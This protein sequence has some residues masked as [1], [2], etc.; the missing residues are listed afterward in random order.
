MAFSSLKLSGHSRRG[1]A[2]IIV[3]AF[4]V[5]LTG[6]LVAFFSL[7]MS[8]RQVSNSS[9]NGGKTDLFARG[10]IDSVVGDFK[11]EIVAGSAVP[12]PLSADTQIAINSSSNCYL[13]VTGTTSTFNPAA[14]PYV[15]GSTTSTSTGIT[16]LAAN[17]VKISAYNQPFYPKGTFYSSAGPSRAADVSTSGTT[18]DG[19]YMTPARWNAALLLP[20]ATPASTSDF[21]PITS[22]TNAFPIPDWVL[23]DRSG[24]NPTTF[25][26]AI[27]TSATSSTAVIGRYA[28]VVYNE[29]G[30]L[31]ANV[32]GGPANSDLNGVTVN[33]TSESTIWARK[34]SAAFADLTQLGQPGQSE[35]P[36]LASLGSS[37]AQQIVD[38]IVGWRNYASAQLAGN[39]PSL[40]STFS[41]TSVSNYLTSI[42]GLNTA[43]MTVG[44]SS[45]Y[46]GQS[47]RAFSSRQQL[48]T[49]LQDIGQNSNDSTEL[50]ALQN[51]LQYLGTFSRSLNQPSFAPDPN[52][53]KVVGGP[54]P[55]T[56]TYMGGNDANLDGT[57]EDNSFNPKFL[58]IRVKTA[59]TRN[60]GTPANVGD[61]LV[62]KRFAL[63]RLC[64]ITPEGPSALLSQ[65]D[66]VYQAYINAGV[67][68]QLLAEGGTANIY[69]YFGL[70]WSSSKSVPI[71]TGT[72]YWTYNHGIPDTN[73]NAS[74]GWLSEVQKQVPEREPDFFELLQASVDVGTLAKAYGG[75][76]ASGNWIDPV[77]NA[78]YDEI[79]DSYTIFHVLQLGA[80]IIDCANPTQYPTV[81]RFPY[82]GDG[83][84]RTI[85]GTT[86]LPYLFSFRNVAYITQPA[87]PEATSAEGTGG[88]DPP[89]GPNS[90]KLT[91][92]GDIA[93]MVVPIIWNPY[94]YNPNLSSTVSPTYLRMTAVTADPYNIDSPS[95]WVLTPSYS[96]TTG[97]PPDLN[98]PPSQAWLTEDSTALTFN[99]RS[100]ASGT[101][102]YLEPTPLFRVN[103]P[104]GSNLASGPKNLI[105]TSGSFPTAT[106][107]GLPEAEVA[108]GVL[109]PTPPVFTGFPISGSVNQRYTAVPT[110]STN[111]TYTVNTIAVGTP[112]YGFTVRLEYGNSSSGPWI[113]YKVFY[114]PADGDA[115]GVAQY[116]NNTTTWPDILIPDTTA[117]NGNGTSIWDGAG[118]GGN[119]NW[120]TRF[121]WDPRTLRWGFPGYYFGAGSGGEILRFLDQGQGGLPITYTVQST[122]FSNA[123]GPGRNGSP[124]AGWYM[125]P[126]NN[127]SF[128]FRQGDICQ[129]FNNPG[130]MHYADAD[131]VIRPSTAAYQPME[132]TS[133]S[134]TNV[135]TAPSPVGIEAAAGIN[136]P[137]ASAQVSAYIPP[138]A[139]QY[140]S[141]PIILHRP[142]RTVAE[143]GYVFRD[144]AWK[145]IDFFTPCSGDGALL[146]TFCINEDTRTDALVAGK[147]DL[148][149]KQVPV[150]QALLAGAYR[151]EL[152]V[153]GTLA[154]IESSTIAADLVIR[155]SGTTT[156]PPKPLA[157][158][159][160]LVG[161]WIPNSRATG[162]GT[163]DPTNEKP[164]YD[165]TACYDGFTADLTNKYST[166]GT[167]NNIV[168]RFR[169]TAIRAL[170]DAGMAGTWDLLID[171][172]AQT[173]RYPATAGNLNNFIV[174]GERRYWAHVAIDRQTGAVIDEQIE[175]V[176]E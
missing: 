85:Y 126:S 172:V 64:W 71:G 16:S 49:F 40:S 32:A 161:R 107:G 100:V 60:D 164:L 114:C 104:T 37:R 46:N 93:V 7:T 87:T 9:A 112:I 27:I 167:S 146:D 58:S 158:I 2:L 89:I 135:A 77:S 78:L 142:Y 24:N 88:D 138:T 113:P 20:K 118:N 75:E 65:G 127:F 125:N 28:Y 111:N 109:F 81:I 83:S 159:A 173:G 149:T 70:T 76:N 12:N 96:G 110:T 66:P 47:D 156:T 163:P 101:A 91:S 154:L 133:M 15:S 31:D 143:L 128:P 116:E 157:N 131:N 117:N 5:L 68:P 144:T 119:V 99:N 102:L 62:K 132:S 38:D 80:N 34:G 175:P 147:V 69:S 25:T 94:I 39:S 36:G 1:V 176:N 50:A 51:T 139:S 152:G 13:Y 150:I 103:Y 79:D 14:V 124:N 155:T 137:E 174:D 82:G 23:V 53:P 86:D 41:P 26:P 120:D 42:I 165:G 153:S 168:P 21:T 57:P 136:D 29:G 151:D 4:V 45:L 8:D 105:L 130:A 18:L 74:V 22:G 122:R 35:Q 33:G 170:S 72:T 43:Y 63:S 140:Q 54:F 90:D 59:F 92:Y 162:I 121:A 134:G 10:A 97:Y 55:A 67:A 11:Q 141:R 115:I 160:D 52:R 95:P 169:E 3:L 44:N 56:G 98:P 84:S 171:I 19:R 129:N 148:N 48:I 6:L 61:P 17:L 106:S 108:K 30:L 145:D 73:G 123:Q 166:S